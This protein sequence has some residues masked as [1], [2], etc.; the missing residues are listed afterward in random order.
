[1]IPAG[2]IAVP[3]GVFETRITVLSSARR[4]SAVHD[5]D[6]AAAAE[7]ATSVREPVACLHL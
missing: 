4:P 1:M 2:P 7:V 6:L 3:A 5:E